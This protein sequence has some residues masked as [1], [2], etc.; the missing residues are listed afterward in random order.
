MN[1]NLPSTTPLGEGPN[2][3]REGLRLRAKVSFSFPPCEIATVQAGSRGDDRA[4]LIANF[5]S[6][7]GSNAPLP[8]WVAE[9]VLQQER[10]HDTALRDF[11]D[12]FHHRLLSLLYRIRLQHRPWLD[13][14]LN[15]IAEEY[16]DPGKMRAR[17]RMSGYMLSFAGIGL[18]ELQNRLG[19]GDE[20]LLPYAGLLW[21][22]PRSMTG[23]ER[24]IEHA[25]A[26]RVSSRQMIGVWR[27]IESEDRTLLGGE[28]IAASRANQGRN[29][30]LGQSATL[31]RRYW[32]PQG[33][34]YLILGPLSLKEFEG[35]LPDGN[36]YRKLRS[37]VRFYAG[38]LLTVR[39]RLLLKTSEAPSMRLN[40]SRLGWT[41][42]LKRGGR[43]SRMRT[44]V[45]GC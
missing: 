19:I 43:G 13:P 34:F 24:V 38:D 36:A 6:L 9:L 20:E 25:F 18:P 33:K 22:H 37:L 1:Q 30:I 35:F 4:E 39:I 28:A 17:N 44:I 2:P 26:V 40:R 14:A 12:I 41:S 10:N 15:A 29:N 42:W 7:A 8:D 16:S 11:L 23:L 31:G 21:Q 45:I 32:D 27:R 3:H 5:F